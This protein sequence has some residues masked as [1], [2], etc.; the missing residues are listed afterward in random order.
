LALLPGRSRN[1]ADYVLPVEVPAPELVTTDERGV[2]WLPCPEGSAVSAPEL[3]GLRLR[4]VALQDLAQGHPL[5]LRALPEATS[6]LALA[7]YGL[8]E[9]PAALQVGQELGPGAP[10]GRIPAAPEGLPR[11][12][13]MLLR[14]REGLSAEQLEPTRWLDPDVS[15]QL[16]PRSELTPRTAPTAP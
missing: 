5:L 10:L 14:L 1:W 4:V 11:L 2:V 16:D 6:R 12:G 8:A 13:L 9:V 15:I 7:L 3:R